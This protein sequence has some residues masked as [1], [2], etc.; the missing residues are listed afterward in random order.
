MNRTN[1][2]S[3]PHSPR[4][5]VCFTKKTLSEWLHIST[6]SLDRAIAAGVIPAPDLTVGRSP[7]WSEQTIAAFLKTKPR[8]PGRGGRS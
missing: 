1:I 8:L 3:Q 6:R 5:E 7:R 2:I 4:E